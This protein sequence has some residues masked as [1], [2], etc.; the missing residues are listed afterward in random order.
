M[1]EYKKKGEDIK[2]NQK[3]FVVGHFLRPQDV[4]MLSSL[5]LKRSYY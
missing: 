5:G 4:G 3:V 1:D 2:K